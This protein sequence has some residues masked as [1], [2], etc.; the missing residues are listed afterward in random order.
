MKKIGLTAAAMLCIIVMGMTQE[1]QKTF[2]P[3]GKPFAK[4]FSNFHS[5]MSDGESASAFE[6]TRV[7]LGYGYSFSKNFSGKLNFDVGN[8]G[9]GGLQMTAYIKNAYL[10]YSLNNLSVSFGLIS[11]TQFKTQEKFWGNRYVEKSFQ[12][13]YK[14]NASADLGVSLAYKLC[15][16]AS[17]D[18]SL[19]NGEGYKK[20]QADSSFQTAIGLTL[21]PVDKITVRG[22][23][24]F[25]PGGDATQSTISGFVG[26]TGSDLSIGA[27]YNYQSNTGR[28]D[29]KD[30]FG[31][32]VYAGYS[33]S[34][35]V[36]LF[37][38]YDNLSSNTLS[39]ATADWNVAKDGQLIIAGL[40]YEPVKGVKLAPNFQSW[41]PASDTKP[42]ITTLLLNCEFKF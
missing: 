32:S 22:V 21:D 2:V 35:K 6:I 24:D 23:Y 40:E 17:V 18:L 11:T 30:V 28:M 37:A 20:L 5:T 1:T 29:A 38:R 16:F 10:N 3:E 9:V 25:L 27:E 26:Y 14:F 7:Y 4:V 13:L 33:P 42:N 41:N 31:T 34:K 36:K 39:G 19:F 8:P 15:D 12:D